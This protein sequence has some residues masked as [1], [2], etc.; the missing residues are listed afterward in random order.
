MILQP[1]PVRSSRTARQSTFAPP[2]DQS[3]RGQSAQLFQGEIADLC[4]AIMIVVP[5]ALFLKSLW[6]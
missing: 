2:F 3:E 4:V 1:I 6:F 5:L